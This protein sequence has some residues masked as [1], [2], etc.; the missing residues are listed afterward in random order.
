MNNQNSTFSAM[1]TGFF[2]GLVAGVLL[3]PEKGEDIRNNIRDKITSTVDDIKSQTSDISDNIED[4][5]NDVRD[6]VSNEAGKAK[7]KLDRKIN[8]N[9]NT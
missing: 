2:I 4:R 7:S 5:V 1:I 6:R 3:A 8:E 9:M